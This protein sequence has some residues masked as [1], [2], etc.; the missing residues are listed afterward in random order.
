MVLTPFNGHKVQQD[1]IRSGAQ[2]ASIY[3]MVT[4]MD[5]S[6][7]VLIDLNTGP[8]TGTWIRSHLSKLDQRKTI[9]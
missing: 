4:P 5:S 7:V 1:M 2:G 9:K 3:F 6:I 8:R